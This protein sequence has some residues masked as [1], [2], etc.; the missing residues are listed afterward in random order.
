MANTIAGS[1]RTLLE[2]A[3]PTIKAYR[4]SAPH[5]APLPRVV[6][7]EGITITPQLHGDFGDPGRDLSLIEEVQVDV[8]QTNDLAVGTLEDPR[9]PEL[10][11]RTLNGASLDGPG[12][13]YG[14]AV[15]SSQRLP[16]PNADLM[17]Q[18]IRCRI[19]RNAP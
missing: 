4:D 8:W 14:V 1:I 17:R 10:V 15:I 13:I 6:I 18:L 11:A 19:T 16:D 2:A 9:L 3:I 7:A 5:D 12:H